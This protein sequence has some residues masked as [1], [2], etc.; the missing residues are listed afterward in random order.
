MSVTSREA[1]N[2]AE[3]SGQWLCKHNITV[4][5]H[6]HCDEH[7]FNISQS[8]WRRRLRT[9]FINIH[10][11]E[12]AN[13]AGITVPPATKKAKIDSSAETTNK[14]SSS[15]MAEYE[16]HVSF[17]KRSYLSK[18]WPRS[19][20]ITLMEQTAH[21]RREWIKTEG[22]TVKQILEN[23]PCLGEPRIVR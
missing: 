20:M 10:R 3:Q 15:L 12:R 17:L 22:P 8:S 2:S 4:Y 14:P 11:P 21:I 19:S 9:K 23:F 18:R 1:Y 13:K 7:I 16:R 6:A 5:M